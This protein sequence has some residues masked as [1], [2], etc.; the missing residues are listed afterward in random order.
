[1]TNKT[2]QGRVAFA[3]IL[4]TAACAFA[5]V[6]N[7]TQ[8]DNVNWNQTSPWEDYLPKGESDNASSGCVPTAYAQLMA[9][10]EWPAI[11]DDTVL[12]HAAIGVDSGTYVYR[13]DFNTPVY[14]KLDWKEM[15]ENRQSTRGS[16]E[17]GRLMTVVGA[18]SFPIYTVGAT[19]STVSC[20]HFNPWYGDFV[21]YNNPLESEA[22]GA[23][24][25]DELF[26][27]VKS[28]IGEKLPLCA[29]FQSSAGPHAIVLQ[30]YR[31][32]DGVP[33][34]YCN[35]GWGGP[36]NGWTS[37]NTDPTAKSYALTGIFAKHA[38]RKMVQVEP[39]PA[40]SPT[41][42]S[43]RWHAPKYWK[44]LAP[45][46]K[47]ITGY[48][49]EIAAANAEATTWTDDF[50]ALKQECLLKSMCDGGSSTEGGVTHLKD[51][52]KLEKGEAGENQ[53]WLYNC[54]DPR[55]YEWPET[56]V[57][58][59][60]STLKFAGLVEYT[61]NMDGFVQ[62]KVAN[63]PW[64]NL[65]DLTE[66]GACDKSPG[67]WKDYSIS[68]A[69]F[70]EKPVKLRLYVA[71]RM[72][73]EYN[74]WS[75][76]FRNWEL[77]NVR[78]FGKPSVSTVSSPTVEM[79]STFQISGTY[80][81]AV[82]PLFGSE[83]GKCF[84][85]VTT[86]IGQTAAN[87][88]Q[89][90]YRDQ[91]PVDGLAFDC[92]HANPSVLT[93]TTTKP[94]DALLAI[95]GNTA[96]FP[97][98][99][100]KAK[101]LGEKTWQVTL[102]PSEDFK[103]YK[104]YSNGQ[105]LLLTI[106]A[107]EAN[108]T[109][110]Y[111]DLSLAFNTKDN[112]PTPPGGGDSGD[113][114]F[115]KDDFYLPA[116]GEDEWI[117]TVGD[118]FDPEEDGVLWNGLKFVR[119]AESKFGA[120]LPSDAKVRIEI[121]ATKKADSWP[122][123]R[124]V[125]FDANAALHV[126]SI[127]SKD[128]GDQPLGFG[129][130]GGVYTMVPSRLNVAGVEV[131]LDIALKPRQLWIGDGGTVTSA[132]V[133]LEKCEEVY[134]VGSL[135]MTQK[136]NT[137]IAEQ[138]D[139]S[140]FK[141]YVIG[142]ETL[143]PAVAP[144]PSLIGQGGE[145][146]G[147]GVPPAPP[148]ETNATDPVDSIYR[149]YGYDMTEN[150]YDARKQAIQKGKMLFVLSGSTSCNWCHQAMIFLQARAKTID[151]QYVVYYAKLQNNGGKSPFQGG[152][153]QY[154]SFDPR[155]VDAFTGTKQADG[156]FNPGAAWYSGHS[157]AFASERGYGE[158]QLGRVIAAVSSRSMGAF[159]GF[160]LEGPQRIFAKTPTKYHLYAHFADGVKM[161]V[162]HNVEWKVEGDASVDKEGCLYVHSG[163]VTLSARNAFY[164][165]NTTE[166]TLSMDVSVVE[167]SEVERIEIDT[168]P[169]NLEDNP[170]VFLKARAVLKD[171]TKT[172][173]LP[174][175]TARIKAF[176]DLPTEA[177]I[178][179]RTDL[180][181]MMAPS[182]TG[183]VVYLHEDNRYN[184][185]NGQDHILEVTATAGGRTVSAE[186]RVY[187]P[188]RL[189]ASDWEIVSG[190]T[191]TLGS[192]IKVKVN[193][194]KYTYAG[195]VLTTKDL[196]YA[197]FE[198][199]A[200][201]D[202]PYNT[203]FQTTPGTTLDL[204]ENFNITGS[205]LQI[206]LGARRKGGKYTG[207]ADNVWKNGNIDER[208]VTFTRDSTVVTDK[209]GIRV[210]KAWAAIYF[211]NETFD[212]ALVDKDSDN[213]GFTNAE[214]FLL[215]TDPTKASDAW[216]FTACHFDWPETVY[217]RVMFMDSQVAGRTYTIEGAETMSGP[218]LALGVMK[219]EA[220]GVIT[221]QELDVAD[222]CR[223]FRV[224][225]S[226]PYGE[227]VIPGLGVYVG[228]GENERDVVLT[229]TRGQAYPAFAVDANKTDYP[230]YVDM[231]MVEGKTA[232]LFSVTANEVEPGQLDR[233]VASER[234]QREGWHLVYEKVGVWAN[235]YAVKGITS[236]S[237]VNATTDPALIPGLAVSDRARYRE[238][239]K[240]P[241][242][243]AKWAMEK[244]RVKLGD[245]INLDCFIL[246][247]ANA[248][249]TP[250]LVIDAD[251]LKRILAAKGDLDAA[252]EAIRPK[253][254]NAKVFVRDVTEAVCGV[255]APGVK[256]FTLVLSL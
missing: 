41:S 174:K 127:V 134:G 176:I 89:V 64:Q 124:R 15:K 212:A 214:E 104:K 233:F 48:Q 7:E 238:A 203:V 1:M 150:F 128:G 72:R 144:D 28:S 24:K 162:D 93:V 20:P 234:L 60:S 147:G 160:T 126:L 69:A 17:C 152:L 136:D 83:T 71:R 105:K 34:A 244:G 236:W 186:I 68:L 73:G 80:E 219:G 23:A 175:W 109:T 199:Q 75:W 87:E 237:E 218:W 215:G 137:T 132:P 228:P 253:Y 159:T 211:P 27:V 193:E 78:T 92:A 10:H 184:G 84:R 251:D 11:I 200:R 177:P 49:V 226:F 29:G 207:I 62:A 173:T 59:E 121:T 45:D 2:V 61:E 101:R 66:K 180:A 194:I 43:I 26:A 30:G 82:K 189:W 50:S 21:Y 246:N 85:T 191:A 182:E 223:Y 40:V 115:T 135:N 8:L 169:Y 178:P 6:T 56:W 51:V 221:G 100:I 185:I 145:G 208:I 190:D 70:K 163:S 107:I 225:A 202:G 170:Q 86:T 166:N 118:D 131:K 76:K 216:K 154:G 204:G 167:A 172:E 77:E 103:I 95:S 256:L 197:D 224:K 227:A 119:G 31:E 113:V 122:Y 157:N 114:T 38:P 65:Y 99:A 97:E 35:L 116:A 5:G 155:T 63:G 25:R 4:A 240:D 196:K 112:D 168:T 47:R 250:E 241:T 14:T 33:E 235:F 243:L 36:S 111:K 165:F 142:A 98:E 143:T 210:N 94:V 55:Y 54:P 198:V 141:G 19:A 183:E 117:L 67:A 230:I 164:N 149:T 242:A 9:Y 254:P 248:G 130:S 39:L 133:Y 46:G 151:R 205:R 146:E 91:A 108:G 171:G 195:E 123:Y 102:T 153:P 44:E 158:V 106:A 79:F 18:Y 129:F 57:A 156:T 13:Q 192:V 74:H 52:I 247:A 249:Q 239:R 16:F 12:G 220:P 209:H 37:R 229:P 96:I 140:G 217:Y 3:T 110:T 22:G 179:E 232:P 125:M 161:E 148:V 181:V 222:K 53:L 88:L 90:T 252:A 32:N 42:L 120:E 201:L 139:L 188:S 255:V 245:R 231:E 206:R 58:T 81:F 213:D 138:V 187:G